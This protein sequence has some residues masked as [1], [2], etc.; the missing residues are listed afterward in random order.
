MPAS[1]GTW[2]IAH[3]GSGTSLTSGSIGTTTAGDNIWA[4]ASDGNNGS[5][6]TGS[7]SNSNSGWGQ[8]GTAQVDGATSARMTVLFAQNIA[9]VGA[10]HTISLSYGS[11]NNI[12][13]QA[14]FITGTAGAS[15]VDTGSLAQGQDSSSPYQIT[16]NA[17]AQSDNFWLTFYLPPDAGLGTEVFTQP[18]SY[19]ILAQV[20]DRNTSYVCATAGRALVDGSAQSVTWADTSTTGNRQLKIVAV[21]SAV[22]ATNEETIHRTI[23][24]LPTNSKSRRYREHSFDGFE[25][26]PPIADND[27]AASEATYEVPLGRDRTP[28]ITFDF[29]G[30]GAPNE[31]AANDSWFDVPTGLDRNTHVGFSFPGVSADIAVS[32]RNFTYD[33]PDGKLFLPLH[34]SGFQNSPLSADQVVQVPLVQP[35]FP[36]FMYPHYPADTIDLY[37]GQQTSPRPAD[38]FPPVGGPTFF[39]PTYRPRRR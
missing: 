10:G 21:K 30:V 22:T 15:A 4:V 18:A 2:V 16:S 11:A 25:Q 6:P 26:N 20:T 9:N 27:L 3:T 5:D 23:D 38:V 34:Y 28:A 7:D 8:L 39:I 33:V 17:P 36:V 31:I 29:P 35:Q 24:E 19:T 12:S 1:A 37:L 13:L 32:A 14:G